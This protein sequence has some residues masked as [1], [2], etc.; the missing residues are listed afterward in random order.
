MKKISEKFSRKMLGGFLIFAFIMLL[1]GF[2]LSRKLNTLLR[3]HITHL[4]SAEAQQWAELTDT[5]LNDELDTLKGISKEIENNE[6]DY[7]NIVDIY[8]TVSKGRDCSYGLLRLDGTAIYG[9]PL[10]SSDFSGIRESFRGNPSI[11]YGKGKGLLFTMPVCHNNNVKYVL[12]KKYATDMIAKNFA[13]FC[14]GGDGYVSVQ[15]T[16]GLIAIEPKGSVLARSEIWKSSEYNYVKSELNDKL[17]VS[18]SASVYCTIAGES[19]Y[20]FKSDLTWTGMSLV[21]VVPAKVAE[22]DLENITLLVIWVFSLLFMLFTIVGVYLLISEQKIQE[23]SDKIRDLSNQIMITLANTIDAKD[24]YT[25]GHSVRVATYSREIA[26]RMGKSE[27]EANRIRYIGLLHDIGKIGI[28]V[29]II[30]KKGRLTDEEY[31]V[32]K[33]HPV[34]G[35]DILK[36][37]TELPEAVVGAHWHHERYDGKGYP[38]GLHGEEIPETARIIGVAD[39]YD[40]MTSNRSYRNVLPQEVVRGEIEKG[41]G[42]QFDPKIAD[43]MLEIIDED[44]YYSKRER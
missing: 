11:S 5:M 29:E 16:D 33:T 13:I 24:K 30:N 38:N 37:M 9:E 23:S 12:Y 6:E 41:K 17:N 36:D 21:G 34:I 14:F 10:Q 20:F 32:M 44:K 1:V 8:S 27:E 42:T 4:V 7:K 2:L 31:S 19:Y 35:A 3:E 26:I 22:N 18:S 25:K 39:A 40:A 28:P 43:V 15:D